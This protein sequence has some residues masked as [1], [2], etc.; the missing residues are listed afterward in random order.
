LKT[1]MDFTSDHTLLD[2]NGIAWR[3][4]SVPKGHPIPP[5]LQEL[6]SLDPDK[7]NF[8]WLDDQTSII[9]LPSCAPRY[10]KIVDSLMFANK[11]GLANCKLMIVDV[12]DNGGG[13]DRT[14]KAL[15]PYILTEP[16]KLPKVGYYTSKENKKMF[17]E[18]GIFQH[19][20]WQND[21]VSSRL[22]TLRP[23]TKKENLSFQSYPIN[24][25]VL[26]NNATA[27]SGETFVMKSK[28]SSRVT[29]FGEVTAGCVDG[30]N[31][32]IIDLNGAKLRYPTSV[33]TLDVIHSA[34][35]PFGLLPDVRFPSQ[36][37]DLINF[38]VEYYSAK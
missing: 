2:E 26:T 20:D 19:L 6:S 1:K 9:T 10:S 28:Q 11:E 15:L 16:L 8:R 29:T 14:Y 12:R 37:D 24:V 27:S 33:R 36:G 18:I 7:P 22:I 30:Y 23:S 13:S 17:K 3:R 5:S 38:V 4:K 25:A 21:T 34:I 35:D 31:G 32:N